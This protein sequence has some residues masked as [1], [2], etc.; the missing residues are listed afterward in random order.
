MTIYAKRLNGPQRRM[1][2]RYES[3]CGFEPLHQEDL[4]A[5]R[6][7]FRDLWH[8]NVRWLEDVVATVSNIHERG[9]GL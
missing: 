8:E 7:T 4:D 9:A 3:V 1:L 6:M 2:N 5:G